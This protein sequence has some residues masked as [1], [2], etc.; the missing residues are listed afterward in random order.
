[1]ESGI[2]FPCGGG[3]VQS[4]DRESIF[5]IAPQLIETSKYKSVELI[6]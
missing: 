4:G 2:Q 3:A 1:M 6:L 5:T